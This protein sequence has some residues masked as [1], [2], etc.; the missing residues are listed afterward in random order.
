MESVGV[1]LMMLTRYVTQSKE[2]INI[3]ITS[4]SLSDYK[5]T[6][7]AIENCN[8]WVMFPSKTMDL[9]LRTLLKKD[10]LEKMLSSI[11]TEE[12]IF[13]HRSSPHFF[14]TNFAAIL[15]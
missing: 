9:Q 14:L 4:H 15:I 13:Y 1:Y 12:R 6:Q 11:K 8:Y 5:R 2:T 10:G 3:I 7:Y